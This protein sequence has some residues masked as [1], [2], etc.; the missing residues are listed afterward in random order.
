MNHSYFFFV[1][2]F[3][4][5]FSV[6]L[7]LNSYLVG[8]QSLILNSNNSNNQ[9]PCFTSLHLCQSLSPHI[10]YSSLRFLTT[11]NRRRLIVCPP[12]AS[13]GNQPDNIP[14]LA[15]E[16]IP[17]DAAEVDIYRLEVGISV[18][19]DGLSQIVDAVSDMAWLGEMARFY[20]VSGRPVSVSQGVLSLSISHLAM[21][22]S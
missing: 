19:H 2:D 16:S 20:S 3:I 4:A 1:F 6:F 22:L 17:R 13:P 14:T 5:S 7:F 9:V 11:S 15:G 21:L 10:P 12:L 8:K 18:T